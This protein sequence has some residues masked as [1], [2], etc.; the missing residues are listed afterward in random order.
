MPTNR[1]TALSLFLSRPKTPKERD[2][3]KISSYYGENV[4]TDNKL[5]SY[6]SND[7]YKAYTQT[8]NNGQKISRELAD[9]IAA[10]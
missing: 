1:S 2:N 6:L 9:Q 7:A 3:A 5:R 4:F 8:I 10:A